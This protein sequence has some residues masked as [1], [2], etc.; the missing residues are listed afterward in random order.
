MTVYFLALLVDALIERQMRRAMAAASIKS[1]PLYPED[2]DCTAPT[3]DR[4]LDLLRDLQRHRLFRGRQL[5]RVFE[6]QLSDAHK[7]ILTLL[8]V[9]LSAYTLATPQ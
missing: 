2:R 1:L 3:T 6:P 8:G 5:V 9:P 7:Q 4:L